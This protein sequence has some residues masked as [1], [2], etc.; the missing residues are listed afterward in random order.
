ME[1]IIRFTSNKNYLFAVNLFLSLLLL[2]VFKLHLVSW[3]SIN[4]LWDIFYSN[5]ISKKKNTWNFNRYFKAKIVSIFIKWSNGKW[6]RYTQWQ[7]FMMSSA[8]QC[9]IF[10]YFTYSLNAMSVFATRE[11][12][13]NYSLLVNKVS[14]KMCRFTR[15]A[16][17]HR[18]MGSS[19]SFNWYFIDATI[20]FYQSVF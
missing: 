13:L 9:C 5:A 16:N 3:A 10:T 20:L 7:S 17:A 2:L 15:S 12:M 11:K 4:C 19:C 18:K 14:S 1:K 6:Y 8:A